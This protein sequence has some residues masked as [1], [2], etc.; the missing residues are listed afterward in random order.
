MFNIN[1]PTEKYQLDLD[2]IPKHVAIIM[3]GNGRWAKK[4]HLPRIAGHKQGM[5]VVKK[6]TK[7]ASDL[8][9]KVLTLYA[10]STENWHRPDKEVNYLMGLPEKFF[11]K[12]VPDLIKNNVQVRVMGEIDNLPNNTKLA[13][14]KAINDTKG[15]DG[16]ILNFALNYGS[17]DEIVTAIKKISK[18]VQD[19]ELKINEID[20]EMVDHSLM[21]ADL[22]SFANPDLLIRTS[23]E[24]R[25]SNFLLWQLAYSEFV[26]DDTKWPDYDSNNLKACI[27]EYQN[28][29]RRFGGI[30]NK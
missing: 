5:E 2:N 6:I 21:T 19:G 20:T 17:H 23:G 28:R 3:D 30:K 9:I 15:C 26:F 10:F 1:R 25:L 13:V 27:Y 24:E 11:N 22:N 12:F 7:S 8:G 16:M 14:N 18:K 4:R 29:H